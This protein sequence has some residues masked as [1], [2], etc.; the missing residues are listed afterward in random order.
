[1][2]T[3]DATKPLGDPDR[4]FR[5]KVMLLYW[6]GD[7]PA[8]AKTSGTHDKTCHW[9]T[10][11]STW[12]P[13]ITRRT[14][15]DFRRFLP[16]NH[17]YRK[18]ASWGAA[19]SRDP[20]PFRTHLEFV[21]QARA[22]MDFVRMDGRAFDHKD[23]PYKATGVKE[24]SPLFEYPHFDMVWDICGDFMHSGVA[25]TSFMSSL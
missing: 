10:Y 5:C 1:M 14:W 6:T 11:K 25:R 7:Y 8:L 18:D 23:S 17:A 12:A 4:V 24:L 9:C 21:A 19:E 15:R 16:M 2:V 20:P 22:Q 13:E 3:V